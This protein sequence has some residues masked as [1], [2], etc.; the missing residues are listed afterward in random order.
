MGKRY[1]MITKESKALLHGEYGCTVRPFDQKV[2]KMACGAKKPIRCRPADLLEPELEKLKKELG[3]YKKQEEDVLTYA[4]FTQVAMEFF[5]KRD[6][7]E[8]NLTEEEQILLKEIISKYAKIPKN[9][10]KIRS[11][12]PI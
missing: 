10:F 6:L 11:V 8:D 9:K 12:K 1:K 3:A 2:Q 4:L 7:E 5:K